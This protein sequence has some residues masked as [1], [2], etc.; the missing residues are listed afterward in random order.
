MLHKNDTEELTKFFFNNSIKLLDS[1]IEINFG[2]N[3]NS[4]FKIGPKDGSYYIS[5]TD[6]DFEN[7]FINYLKDRTKKMIFD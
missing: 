6:K 1:S 3:I 2:L 7:Y 4:D 5:F